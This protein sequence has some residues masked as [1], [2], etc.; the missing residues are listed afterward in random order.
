VRRRTFIRAATALTVAAAT[1]AATGAQASAST[2][3]MRLRPFT[4][5]LLPQVSLPG[6][7]AR[8]MS[9]ILPHATGSVSLDS[10][11][12]FADP[13][14]ITVNGRTY[15][16]YLSVFTQSPAFGVAPQ[17]DVQLD[18][19]TARDGHLTG[20]QDHIYGY[21]PLTGLTLTTNADL[22]RA[23]VRSRTSIDPSA[24]DMRFRASGTA[25]QLACSLI[26]GGRGTFQVAGGSLS[27]STFKIATGTVPFFG[28]ITTP[29]ATGTVLH[30]PGCGS[31][32]SSA[33]AAAVS[34]A[35]VLPTTRAYIF[36]QPCTGPT[37][38][39]STFTTFWL[40]QLGVRRHRLAQLG[41]TTTN[42]FGPGT[43]HVAIGLGPGADMGR[44]V[45]T[46]RGIHE[47]VRT[48]GVPF[49]GGASI[50]HAT[51]RPHVSPGHSCTWERHTYH[52]TNVRYQG[53][54]T[55]AGTPLAVKFDTGTEPIGKVRATLWVPQYRGMN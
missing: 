33:A 21:A 34:R 29:P 26:T 42:P 45:H 1:L 4:P 19:T 2:H 35:H 17:V 14:D 15:Q 3:G 11:D 54:L 48:K 27:A 49:M 52:Y 18:R 22:T 32:I 10:T 7:L 53:T 30:D 43:T 36:R 20:E 13:Q 55:P 41:Q 31:F 39:H 25:E 51:G 12:L 23:H 38:V 24:I 8:R 40:S 50:F 28:D 9:R 47:A 16:M 5:R 6:G 44:I 37:L 46:A